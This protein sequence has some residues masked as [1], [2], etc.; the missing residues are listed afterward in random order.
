MK[1]DVVK[2]LSNVSTVVQKTYKDMVDAVKLTIH[3]NLTDGWKKMEAHF[4]VKSA[5]LSVST[6]NESLSRSSDAQSFLR[7]RSAL[8]N[9][10]VTKA[11]GVG[12]SS[13]NSPSVGLIW[14][15]DCVKR[16]VR[17]VR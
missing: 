11:L 4:H 13:S 10:R 2:R 9:S 15:R 16:R 6:R 8:F 12:S 1:N 7:K 3:A 14:S 5:R 17:S